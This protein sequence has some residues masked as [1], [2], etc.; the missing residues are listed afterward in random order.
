MTHAVLEPVAAPPR[1]GFV[2]LLLLLLGLGVCLSLGSIDLPSAAPW[3]LTLIRSYT[4]AWACYLIAAVLVMRARSLPRWTVAWVVLI[5]AGMH[6]ACYLH[7]LPLSD[8]NWRYLWDG[9]VQAAGI[10]PYLYPPNAPELAFLRDANWAHVWFKT[11]PTVYPPFAQLFFAALARLREADLAAFSWA[12]MLCNLG[13]TLLLLPLLRRTGR[14]AEH[15]IWFSWNPLPVLETASGGHVDSLSVLLLLAALLLAA[16]RQGR[17]GVA[18]ALAYAASVLAKG[19]AL[20]ALPFFAAAGRWRFL[21]AFLLAGLALS[22]PY[23]PAGRHLFSGLGFYL[24]HWQ[25]NSSLFLLLR[26]ALDHL[27]G[28]RLGVLLPGAAHEFAITRAITGMLVLGVAAWLLYHRRPGTEGLLRATFGVLAAH[29][30]L[31]APVL[32]WYLL[33][34]VPFLC[35]W[36][37]AGWVAFTLTVVV[38]YYLRLVRP[39]WY[40]LPL[41]LGYVPVY[42]LLA[43]AW[44]RG[45]VTAAT[46][47]VGRPSSG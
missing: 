1:R 25:T 11:V 36:P 5:A 30:L 7:R 26:A 3:P 16:R 28:T 35:W 20:L 39:E 43:G 9:R 31:S 4:L 10:N 46:A 14:R 34:T 47:A 19:P 32:P 17:P 33:I 24:S 38:Q 18:S 42:A 21:A 15:V 44:W 41:L 12:F 45:R 22:L 13:C 23:L 6:L 29:L 37:V 8:D 40:P 27:T 2:P